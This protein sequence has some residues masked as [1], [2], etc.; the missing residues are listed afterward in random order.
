MKSGALLQ[1]VF[2]EEEDDLSNPTVGKF[3][4]L[5]QQKS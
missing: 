2:K 4:Y 1:H 5:Q 3:G